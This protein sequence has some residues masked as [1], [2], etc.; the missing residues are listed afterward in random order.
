MKN[1]KVHQVITRVRGT[2]DGF[3]NGQRAVTVIAVVIAIVGGVVFFQWANK[4]T[5]MPLFTSLSQQD[6][7][8]ITQKLT[9]SGTPYEL[10]GTTVRVPAD[11]VDQ[12]RLDL[13]GAG[14]PAD[15]KDAGGYSLVTEAPMT[16]SDSQQRI[17]IKQATEGE[18]RKTIEKIETVQAASVNL[19]LP[20][21]D[22]FTREQAKTTAAVLVTPQPNKEI[23][24]PQVEAIVHLVSSSVPKLDAT[25]V[26]VTDNAGKLLSAPGAAGA[27]GTGEARVAQQQAASATVRQSVQAMLDKAV[28]PGNSSVSV[29]AE[30]GYDDSYI[31][32]NEYI[33]PPANGVPLQE[34]TKTE[35]MD[36]SGQT[37]VGGVLGPDNIPVP[38]ANAAGGTSKY[39][40]NTEKNINAV[41]TQ[42]TVTKPAAGGVKRLAVAVM[43][44]SR[45]AAA[46]NQAQIQQLIAT[47]AG[48]DPKRGD[49]VTVQKV[50]FN[51]QAA[52]AQEAAAA[53]AAEQERRDDLIALIK[54][55]G[56]GLL[57]LL[58]LLIGFRQSRKRTRTVEV[59]TIEATPSLPQ[60]PAGGGAAAAIEAA[61][62]A[63]ELDDGDDLRVLEATPIDAQGQA[64][65]DAREEI[66]NL[67]EENPDEVARLLR[68]WMAERN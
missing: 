48:I 11:A 7:S 6:A 27:S 2:F 15:T 68:G 56:L 14:L 51:T 62:S 37:P 16:T 63:Y 59:S 52:Q 12:T 30:L 22:V 46:V 32:R 3:T 61:P 18:L 10:E 17:L 5:M 20:E 33:Q 39:E 19:A 44:D 13:A 41:G 47:A 29:Q 45:Q 43:L 9:E 49:L 55:I 57:V 23:T 67:V 53:A 26:T 64:R 35:T 38:Q 31:T 65:I 28:G 34:E 21:P 60:L 66:G 8:A 36:G 40:S 24:A 1:A 50:P 58:A 54:N 25:S 42:T 4:P